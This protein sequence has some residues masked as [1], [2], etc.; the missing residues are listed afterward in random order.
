MPK[1]AAKATIM[2]AAAAML[3]AE[4]TCVKYSEAENGGKS[5]N[6]D[7]RRR[8]VGGGNH[9]RKIQ[10]GGAEGCHGEDKPR[11]GEQPG[12]PRWPAM[13]GPAVPAAG[14]LGIGDHKLC[15]ASF[16]IPA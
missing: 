1:I 14:D 11:G 7:R 5:D 2:I 16:Q 12:P 3:A 15:P 8:I 9:G 6:N 10:G 13:G 4:I